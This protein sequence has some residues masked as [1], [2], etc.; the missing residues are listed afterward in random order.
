MSRP[1]SPSARPKK[2]E[3]EAERATI[4]ERWEK[5]LAAVKAVGEARVALDGLAKDA[6]DYVEKIQVLRDAQAE[7]GT[8]Q[9][10]TPMVYDVVDRE[11]VAEVL[12]GWTGIPV[13]S[14]VAGRDQIAPRV[15]EQLKKRIKGQD[16]ALEIIGQTVKTARAG[17]CRPEEAA[18]R[19]LFCGTS[20]VG[21][22][23]TA[24]AL[25]EL[26]YGGEQNVTTINMS[27]FKEEHKVST[28][29][30]AAPG[31]VGYGEGG[32]L[33]EAVRRKPLFRHSPG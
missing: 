17:P 29:V 19:V 28:L 16:Y 26:L 3:L 5:E 11:V 23:E 10:K 15:A 20:G 6:P 33:T 22:T 9:G 27:E 30:G 18:R 25:A 1:S 31:Y 13:G 14:M 21:K 4:A 24:L 8:L 2:A 7:L 32:V 12:A